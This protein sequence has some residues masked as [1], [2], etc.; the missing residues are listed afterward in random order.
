MRIQ[1]CFAVCILLASAACGGPSSTGGH[2]GAPCAT[3]GSGGAGNYPNVDCGQVENCYH[4]ACWDDPKGVCGSIPDPGGCPMG[5]VHDIMTNACRACT[6]DDCDGLASFC[7]GTPA[8]T[9]NVACGLYICKEIDAS[10]AAVTSASC[11]FHDLDGDDAWGDCD[12]AP[13][14]PCCWCKIAV[15]CSDSPCG[16]GMYV[17]NNACAPCTSQTCGHIACMGLNG[18]DSHCPPTQYFDGFKCRDC[19]SSDSAALIPACNGG[20]TDAGSP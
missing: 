20:T 18:C 2:G 10:C 14:D 11:G 13:S 1:S 16:V 3:S 8:C 6:A 4:I 17:N 12:E 9:G 5:Q 19:S 15:G 7:C